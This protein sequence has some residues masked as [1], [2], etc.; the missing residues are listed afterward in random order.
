MFVC[1]QQNEGPAKGELES[2][3][4]D[5]TEGVTIKKY[6]TVDT[7]EELLKIAEEIPQ[8]RE[9][10]GE[11]DKRYEVTQVIEE[12][13]W[14]DGKKEVT[15]ATS[16]IVTKENSNSGSNGS[17]TAIGTINYSL[18]FEDLAVAL[19]IKFN[20]NKGQIILNGSQY[21]SDCRLVYRSDAFNI[22][23][24]QN[25]TCSIATTQTYQQNINKGYYQMS[26]DPGTE[27]FMGEFDV[28]IPGTSELSVFFTADWEGLG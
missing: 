21:P 14:Q 2:I 24:S 17:I 22:G 11:T 9:T 19:K 20:H 10:V 5:E 15:L 28:T 16:G 1:A 13:I 4:Y 3:L 26:L 27:T 25:Y 6:A 12:K 8:T 18:Q 23:A 7:I